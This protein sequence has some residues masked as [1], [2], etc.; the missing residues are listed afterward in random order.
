MAF[1]F[2]HFLD[3]YLKHLCFLNKLAR[4][5]PLFQLLF[6]VVLSCLTLP[7][8]AQP[9]E[10]GGDFYLGL[11]GNFGDSRF[12]QVIIDP[13]TEDVVFNPLSNFSSG[14]SLNALG[15]RS[16]DNYIYGINPRTYELNRIGS[17]GI[18]TPL[19][20]ITELNFNNGYFAADFTPDGRY[21]VVLGS[22]GFNF[23]SVELVFIDF[24]DPGYAAETRP[25][26]FNSN[27]LVTDIAFDPF[28]GILYG[29]DLI[30][31]RLII[32]D[33]QTGIVDDTTF[34]ATTVADAMG[35]IFFDPFGRLYGYGNRFGENDARALFRVDVETG[36]VEELA[37]GPTAS[38]K[39]GCSCP[40]TIRLE[41]TVF[42]RVTFPCTIVE[43]EFEVANAA[44]IIQ[45]GLT[46][47]DEMPQ[48]LLI[49]E[50]ISNPF[51]GTVISGPGSNTLHIED[52]VVPPGKDI[53]RVRVEVGE[54]TNGLYPN[55]A[56]LSG[57][58]SALGGSTLSDDPLTLQEMDPTV[59]SVQP[60]F[61]DLENDT[62]AICLGDSMVLDATTYGVSYQWSNGSSTPSITVEDPG[63]HTVTISTPC[64]TVAD[65]VFLVAQDVEVDA[66]EDLEIELGD[67]IQLSAVVYPG[68]GVEYQWWDPEGNSL[69]CVN[70]LNPFAS[71]VN[72]ITYRIEAIA[73]SC[74]EV[75]ELKVRV[76]KNRGFFAPNVFSPNGD[77]ANDWFYLQG[78]RNDRIKVMRIFNRWGALI[79]EKEGIM[80]NQET[81]GWDGTFQG[82]NLNPD[83]FVWY[84][85]I[86]YA[87]GEV[88]PQSGDVIIIR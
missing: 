6:G 69:S 19:E 72:D 5:I 65:S 58:P 3:F 80:L 70:C 2:C 26:V 20:T 55:Q 50:I 36:E 37:I 86:E 66:G 53:I 27:I 52:M 47:F 59:L 28:S 33:S 7:V 8:L 48:D 22:T 38:G 73:G 12:Y 35:A 51:G 44:G 82:R 31:N 63:W 49:T 15:Y 9:F 13:V 42:P 18:A 21:L 84:A 71:P 4:H 32:I 60:L 54:F 25:L 85:E 83:V 62:V 57:L 17:D 79:F 10:C 14:Q 11:S 87:D 88:I 68:S 61:V 24:D 41:K 76:I 1:I 67:S 39:D 74:Q 30:G 43:Y 34:P 77:G 29:F 64:E 40:Y 78:K 46:I 75:D 81:E 23:H 56:S 45:T 16:V